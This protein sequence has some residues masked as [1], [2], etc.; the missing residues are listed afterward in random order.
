MHK[1]F[2][3]YPKSAQ[4]Y[5]DIILKNAQKSFKL[6]KNAEKSVDIIVKSAH[7]SLKLSLKC[8]KHL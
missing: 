7:R 3:N 4:G 8:T 5:I 6:S 2:R 1:N